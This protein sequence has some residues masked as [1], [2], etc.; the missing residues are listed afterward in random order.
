MLE[1][2][3]AFE[4]F[5]D[6]GYARLSDQ[7]R[8][9]FLQLL[10]YPDPTLLEWIMGKAEPDQEALAE[11]VAQIRAADPLKNGTVAQD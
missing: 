10:E 9:L 8:D 3:L 1:L 11:L 2:D 4:R 5:L 7:Q 6:N